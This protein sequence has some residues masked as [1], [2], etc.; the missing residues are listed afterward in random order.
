LPPVTDSEDRVRRIQLAL[1]RFGYDPGTADN[2][3]GEKTV[4]AIKAYQRK[5][6]LA[7]TGEASLELLRHILDQPLPEQH[8]QA[9]T[10]NDGSETASLRAAATGSRIAQIQAALQKFGYDPGRVDNVVGRKTRSAI[11]SYQRRNGLEPTGEP[12]QELLNHLRGINN[13]TGTP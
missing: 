3:P 9:N 1:Q 4:S 5:H 13:G 8:A 12:S 7:P 2:V 10:G 6:G 11:L